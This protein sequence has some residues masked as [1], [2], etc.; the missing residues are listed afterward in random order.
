MGDAG[1]PKLSWVHAGTPR[2]SSQPHSRAEVPSPTTPIGSPTTLPTPQL[3]GASR[4]PPALTPAL[5]G[6]ED[7]LRQNDGGL[8]VGGLLPSQSLIAWQPCARKAALVQPHHRH[9]CSGTRASPT[10]QHMCARP[11]THVNTHTHPWARAAPAVPSTHDAQV[12]R[13]AHTRIPQHPN[14]PHKCPQAH[15]WAHSHLPR[16]HV[17]PC[18]HMRP[19]T[20][21]TPTALTDVGGD[22]GEG[23]EVG[24]AHVL[25]QG[26]G[27]VLKVLQQ[28]RRAAL[29]LL[30]QLPVPLVAGVQ[31]RAAHPQ[32]VL[33]TGRAAQCPSPQHPEGYGPTLHGS[34]GSGMQRAPSTLHSPRHPDPMGAPVSNRH[35]MRTHHCGTQAPAPLLVPRGAQRR[36]HG[37]QTPHNHWRPSA[38][39]LG[40]IPQRTGHRGALSCS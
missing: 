32:Q 10:A 28:P 20:A 27:V 39:H 3:Q 19:Q 11:R 9:H 4:H 22:D 36:S 35:L 25:C 23:A 12:P 21:P 5:G 2:P 17:D 24:L 33:E 34:L 1:S 18:V 30:D 13:C 6:P 8:Q 16:H 14:V 38:W 37:L 15:G 31:Q 29:R 26:A 40:S 7:A